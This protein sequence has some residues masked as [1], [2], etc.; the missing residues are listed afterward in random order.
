MLSF[1]DFDFLKQLEMAIRYGNPVLFEDVDEYIDPV[2]GNV[3]EKNYKVKN[4]QK[5]V[6]LGDKEI[7][8]DPNFYMYLTTKLANP[9]LDPFVYAKAQVINYA[10]T[11]FGLEDQLL[12]VVVRNEKSELEEQRELLVEETSINKKLLQNLED[13]LLRELT[14]STGNMLDNQELINTLDN[15]KTKAADV[16]AKLNLAIETAVTIDETRNEFRPAAKR[17]ANLFFVLADMATVNAMY[18]YSLGAYLGVFKYSLRKALADTVL[19]KRLRNILSVLTK[20]VYEYGCTGIFEKHKLLFSFQMTA[21]LQ[22]SE[23]KLFQNELDFFIK[24]SVAL[25]KNERPCPAK[26]L[27]DKGWADLLKLSVDF[28]NEFADVPAHL[29]ENLDEWKK[30]YDLETP[31]AVGKILLFYFKIF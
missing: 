4:G 5:V 21:R 27:N 1:N 11:I 23:G 7:D 2:I 28:A 10:V 20:N 14:G 17:G 24:G 16:T 13:S 25:E 19:E 31:E 18:Q 15:T 3:L 12:S 6:L 8:V 9:T 30:W 22:Q 29:T 26:W